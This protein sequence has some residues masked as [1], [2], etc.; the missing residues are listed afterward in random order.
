MNFKSKAYSN[1]I[2]LGGILSAAAF[3]IA[4]AAQGLG[5]LDI[6]LYLAVTPIIIAVMQKGFGFGVLVSAVSSMLVCLLLGPFPSGAYF[7]ITV[8]PTAL[9]LGILI[10]NRRKYSETI[11]ILSSSLFLT[12]S[13]GLWIL[14]ASTGISFVDDVNTAAK[15]SMKLMEQILGPSPIDPS[16]IITKTLSLFY[17]T[18][19]FVI[20][21]CSICYAFYLWLFNSWILVRLGVTKESFS[22]GAGIKELLEYP[23]YMA[24]ALPILVI[25]P[26]ILKSAGADMSLT[27]GGATVPIIAAAFYDIALLL[28]FLFFAKGL[29]T[30]RDFLFSKIESF[31]GRIIAVLLICTVFSPATAFMGWYICITGRVPQITSSMSQNP[32]V[33]PDK[34][35]IELIKPEDTEPAQKKRSQKGKK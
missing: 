26:S 6:V 20:A 4:L 22:A 35:S 3:V 28:C 32:E 33:S 24:Y 15:A 11:L 12:I 27:I 5:M 19:P 14:S 31:A 13:G 1:G 21:C 10:K 23:K 29:F 34:V 7:A 17:M 9:T 30:L 2:V 16:Y 18:L 25:M 8:L